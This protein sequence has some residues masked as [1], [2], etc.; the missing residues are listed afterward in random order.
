MVAAP[1]AATDG[2]NTA[3]T[4]TTAATVTAAEAVSNGTNAAAATA[5]TEGDEAALLLPPPMPTQSKW[6]A[7]TPDTS[8]A[9]IDGGGSSDDNSTGDADELVLLASAGRD[10]LVKV[11]DLSGHKS[12]PTLLQTLDTHSSSVTAVKFSKVRHTTGA[13]RNDQ[14][15]QHDCV[16]VMLLT[17]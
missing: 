2:S 11:Y 8:A 9:D 16:L 15:V 14:C 1:V 10:R 12:A 6:S 3:S 17:S 13:M 4:D 5:V 7:V